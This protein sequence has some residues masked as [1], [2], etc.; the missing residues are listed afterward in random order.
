[1]AQRGPTPAWGAKSVQSAPKNPLT[2]F[3]LDIRDE[4]NDNLPL[5]L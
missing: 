1:M 5:L 4:I 2:G 3:Y